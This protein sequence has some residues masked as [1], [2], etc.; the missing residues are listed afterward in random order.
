MA[1][2]RYTKN[3][4][5]VVN[6]GDRFRVGL[7]APAAEE[8]GDVTF[9]ELPKVGRTVAAGE[10]LCALEAVKAAADFYSPLSGKVAEVNEQLSAAPE[11]LGTHPETDG[12]LCVLI[13]VPNGEFE[14]LLTE[15]EWKVW[16]AGR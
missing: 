13:G 16:E 2:R 3:G 15:E 12:W 10:A 8:L 5:W 1:E 11:L 14:A 7:T 9:V 6:E 4:E